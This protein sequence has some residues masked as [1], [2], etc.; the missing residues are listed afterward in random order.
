[1]IRASVGAFSQQ[2]GPLQYSLST[3]QLDRLRCSSRPHC[4]VELDESV[5]DLRAE[6]TGRHER[7]E[8]QRTLAKSVGATTLT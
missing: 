5:G 3:H 7:A 8:Q 2:R 1:M 4:S 6:L